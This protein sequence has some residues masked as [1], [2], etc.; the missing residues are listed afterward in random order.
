[1]T[2]L[3]V[4]PNTQTETAEAIINAMADR[5]REETRH[6]LADEMEV[7]GLPTTFSAVCDA[8]PLALRNAAS[9]GVDIQYVIT[10]TRSPSREE[11]AYAL[12]GITEGGDI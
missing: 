7:C 1:M 12:L 3:T 8:G 4:K 10:G 9:C 5:Y 2:I 11:A 6:W